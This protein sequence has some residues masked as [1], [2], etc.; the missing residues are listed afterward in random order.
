MAKRKTKKNQE[1]V[2]TTEQVEQFESIVGQLSALHAEFV[3]QAKSKPDSPINKFKLKVLNEKLATANGILEGV[4]QPFDGFTAFDEAEFPTNSDVSLV[5]TTYLASLERWRSGH[6]E[7]DAQRL[8]WYW[9]TTDDGRLLASK[10]TRYD[11][12]ER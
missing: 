3:A 5:L 8:R 7:H 1:F 10:P 11:P 2:T 12:D 4:F 9:K 6:V